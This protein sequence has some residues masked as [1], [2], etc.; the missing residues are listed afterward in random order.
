MSRRLTKEEVFPSM[1]KDKY[2]PAELLSGAHIDKVV[3]FRWRFPESQV[4]ALVTGAIREIHHDGNERV[5]LQ[6]IPQDA[7]VLE[8]GHDK[9]EFT[10]QSED[11]VEF[12]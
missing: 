9:Q 6:L 8:V 3:R 5:Y 12:L 1:D 2:I 11:E 10:L 4:Q 7:D